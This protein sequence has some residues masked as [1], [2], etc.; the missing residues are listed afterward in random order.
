MPFPLKLDMSLFYHLSALGV[1][2]ITLTEEAAAEVCDGLKG[3]Y[4]PDM[5]LE[6]WMNDPKALGKLVGI[7]FYKE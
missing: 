1:R 4:K 6:D 7:S 3:L 2:K 5:P